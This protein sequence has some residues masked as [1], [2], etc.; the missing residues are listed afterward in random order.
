[1]EDDGL[2]FDPT[3]AEI[4][5]TKETLDKKLSDIT[6]REMIK[7]MVL[8][9][10]GRNPR[11]IEYDDVKNK[12]FEKIKELPGISMYDIAKELKIPYQNVKYHVDMLEQEEKIRGEE[13]I[14]ENKRRKIRF[15]VVEVSNVN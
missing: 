11:I 12:I 6:L 5:I 14:D 15:V 10:K 3:S 4:V 13:Y 2:I 7:L 8:I 9:K 1:M